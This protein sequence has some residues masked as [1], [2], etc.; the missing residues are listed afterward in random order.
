MKL[1]ADVVSGFVGSILSSRFD[2]SVSSPKFHQELWSEACSDYK[3]VA[4]AAPRGHAK[5]TAGTIAYG[6]A[7]VLFRQAEFVLIVS[8]TE[9][10]SSMFL[11]AIKQELQEN[12]AIRELFGLTTNEKGEVT[13]IKDTETDVI[14]SF[15]DGHKFRIIAKGAEQKLRGMLW[16]GKRPDLILVDDLENDELVMNKD[17]RMKLRRWFFSALLP[18]MSVSGKLRMWGTVLHMDALLESL[19]PR[20]WDKRT[21]REELKD[22]DPSQ[23]NLHR[24]RSIKYRAHNSDFTQLLWPERFDRNFF[25]S[26]RE[27]RIRQGIPDSYSQEYLNRPIDDTLAYFKRTDFREEKE[28]EKDVNMTVYITA[29]LAISEKDTA[30]YSVFCVA[31][32]DEHRRLHILNVVRDRLDGRQIVDLILEL[33][34]VYRPQAIGIEEMQ[35]SKAIGPFLREE[36]VRSGDFPL[37]VPLKHGGKDKIQR[38]RNIQARMRAKSVMFDKASDWFPDLEDEMLRFPRGKHDDQVD[39]M[40]YLGMLL[41]KMIEAPTNEELDEEEYQDELK[42]SGWN[43]RGRSAVTG[44]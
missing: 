18:A 33:Y 16:N 6:L 2:Q 41:D 32:M 28:E 44:Y 19:M 31:G 8:D 4:I 3:Y 1:T 13:F 36:M 30:D 25:E 23:T 15:T 21:I 27:E 29:D 26:K 22:Y 7:A 39:A 10:Q 38:A 9:S 34:R 14:V 17:R 43:T 20:E 12:E 37:I 35:V 5:S 11:G 24:W 42:Q 40:A